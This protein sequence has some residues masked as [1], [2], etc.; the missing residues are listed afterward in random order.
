M[1]MSDYIQKKKIFVSSLYP[2]LG[3]C[4]L[5]LREHLEVDTTLLIV[6]TEFETTTNVIGRTQAAEGKEDQL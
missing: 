2:V 6:K 1:E 5:I 3:G 4:L